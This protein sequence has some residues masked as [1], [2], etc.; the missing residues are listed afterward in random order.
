[1]GLHLC[2][3]SAQPKAVVIDARYPARVAPFVMLMCV[4]SGCCV[5]A[6][7]S[8]H[9]HMM[10]DMHGAGH[11]QPFT[12][13]RYVPAF[14]IALHLMVH[15]MHLPDHKFL[16]LVRHAWFLLLGAVMCKSHHECTVVVWGAETSPS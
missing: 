1:V 2:S 11:A 14:G 12:W 7:D 10:S 16:T 6:R 4:I 5:V 9:A 15:K 3:L 8:I 13:L